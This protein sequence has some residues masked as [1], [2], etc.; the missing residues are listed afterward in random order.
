MLRGLRRLGLP[1]DF[2]VLDQKRLAFRHR[3]N[4]HHGRNSK[5]L[6]DLAVRIGDER[7]RQFVV[8]LEFFLRLRRVAAHAEDLEVFGLEALEGVAQRTSLRCAAGRVGFGIKENQNRTLRVGLGE[9]KL[10]AILVPCRDARGGRP[11][12]QGFDFADQSEKTHSKK[13]ANNL[14]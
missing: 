8:A 1:D 7:E 11:D 13:N 9:A 6:R 4:A 3:Q 14:V 5:R 2:A 10:R 12:L